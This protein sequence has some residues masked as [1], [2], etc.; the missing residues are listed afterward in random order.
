MV[1]LANSGGFTHDPE[2]VFEAAR[3]LKDN[4]GIHFLLSGEGDLSREAELLGAHAWFQKP[5]N[6]A[7]LLEEVD[8]HVTPAT[9]GRGA[10][11][12]PAEACC[13]AKPREASGE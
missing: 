3:I 5:V 12:L 2:S 6:V 1:T 11:L 13:A 7:K 10:S 8:R 4:P 9:A